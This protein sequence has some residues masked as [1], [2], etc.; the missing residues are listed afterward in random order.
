MGYERLVYTRHARRRMDERN[1]SEAEI[2]RL[3]ELR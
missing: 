3:S 2:S 1:I